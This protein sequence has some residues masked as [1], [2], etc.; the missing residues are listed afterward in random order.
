MLLV[1]RRI[2]AKVRTFRVALLEHLAQDLEP[3]VLL[4][5]LPPRRRQGPQH[6]GAEA[7]LKQLDPALEER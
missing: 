2:W 3:G 1:Y 6:P 5:E 7:R 4:A